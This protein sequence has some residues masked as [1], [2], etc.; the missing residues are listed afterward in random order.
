MGA[1]SRGSRLGCGDLPTMGAVFYLGAG[2]PQWK[3]LDTTGTHLPFKRGSQLIS[4]ILNYFF[5]EFA[6]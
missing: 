3:P 1:W 6:G 4:F 5:V 2:W